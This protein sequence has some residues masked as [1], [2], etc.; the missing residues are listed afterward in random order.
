M[1]GDEARVMT[2]RDNAKIQATEMKFMRSTLG[3]TIL[4]RK[5]NVYIRTELGVNPLLEQLRS[6]K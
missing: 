5:K 6:N 3:C 4:D 1:Y 2:E